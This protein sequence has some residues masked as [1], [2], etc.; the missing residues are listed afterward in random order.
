MEGIFNDEE[1]QRIFAENDPIRGLSESELH[2]LNDILIRKQRMLDAS[3][4]YMATE[5]EKANINP[6][7]ANVCMQMRIVEARLSE[8]NK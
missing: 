8:K 7:Y 6:E 5:A 4:P 2:M 3:M 1:I